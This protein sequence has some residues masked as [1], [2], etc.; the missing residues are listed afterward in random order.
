ML[1]NCDNTDPFA[2]VDLARRIGHPKLKVSL[3]T[4]HADICHGRCDAPHVVDH[5]AAAAGELA[6]VHLQ[7]VDGYADR[8]WHPGDGR[9]AW[10]PVFGALAALAERPRLTL[11]V[12]ARTS[13]ACP[14]PWPGR[15]RWAWPADRRGRSARPTRPCIRMAMRPGVPSISTDDTAFRAGV[16][17]ARIRLNIVPVSGASEPPRIG[18]VLKLSDYTRNAT[19]PSPRAPGAARAA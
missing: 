10:R 16:D 18:A 1:E 7:D 2:R 6:H 5:V 8:H 11:E 3:D 14:P 15:R 12:R 13:R 17:A 4:G 9:I 19:I